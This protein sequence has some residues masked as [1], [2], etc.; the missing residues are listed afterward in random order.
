MYVQVCPPKPQYV[1]EYVVFYYLKVKYAHLRYSFLTLSFAM[2]HI[3]V[4]IRK[5]T[6]SKILHWRDIHMW[7]NWLTSHGSIFAPRL[8]GQLIDIAHIEPVCKTDRF[9]SSFSRSEEWS[10]VYLFKLLWPNRSARWSCS[11]NPDSIWWNLGG[12]E[13]CEM[14]GVL[15]CKRRRSS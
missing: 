12:R 8:N 11:Y 6:Y 5:L 7:T 2:S 14:E 15:W 10:S 13:A 9:K 1:I 3:V 4:R